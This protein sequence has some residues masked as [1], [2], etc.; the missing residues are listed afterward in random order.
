MNVANKLFT[1]VRKELR[2]QPANEPEDSSI[3]NILLSYIMEKSTPS[4]P[5][6]PKLI[7]I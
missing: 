7:A 5:V 6:L 1:W 4:P 2:K 3:C